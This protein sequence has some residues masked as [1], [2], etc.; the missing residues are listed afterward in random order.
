VNKKIEPDVHLGN[1]RRGEQAVSFATISYSRRSFVSL[2]IRGKN[3]GKSSLRR[4]CIRC[5]FC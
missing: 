2:H 4:N 5:T 3:V 1:H